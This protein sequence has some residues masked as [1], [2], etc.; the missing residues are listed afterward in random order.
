KFVNTRKA[1]AAIDEIIRKAEERLILISPY[2]KLSNDFRELLEF[3]NNK[4]KCTTIIFGKQ[5]L[6]P[7]EMKFLEGLRFIELKYYHNLHAKCYLNEKQM[8][9]TSL[10]LYDFS[11][12]N[13]KEM[14]VLL[15]LNDPN[16]KDLYNDAWSE[17]ELIDSN[18][19][20]FEFTPDGRLQKS[21]NSKQEKKVVTKK[22]KKHEKGKCIR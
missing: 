21:S 14:G 9:I 11:M 8:V 7:D 18:S 5:E 20:R 13:N 16:D 17:I 19:E 10:N 4:N 1:A 3:R 22:R 2:L 6:N 15:D 12:V